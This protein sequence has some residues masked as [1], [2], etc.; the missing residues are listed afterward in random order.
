MKNSY[1]ITNKTMYRF[2][3]RCADAKEAAV[4]VEM[5]HK[6]G[7]SHFVFRDIRKLTFYY[8]ED[9]KYLGSGEYLFQKERFEEQ[10]YESLK[11]YKKND[12]GKWVLV[13]ETSEEDIK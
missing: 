5:I 11:L 4:K 9:L 10:R 1:K 13:E 2:Y 3:Y 6:E 12:K 8:S 7:M